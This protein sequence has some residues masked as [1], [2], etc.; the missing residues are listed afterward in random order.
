M[1][2]VVTFLLSLSLNGCSTNLTHTK[3]DLAE[4]RD[5][6]SS[7]TGFDLAAINEMRALS[8]DF[9]QSVKEELDY[10]RTH[11]LNAAE[12]QHVLINSIQSRK[13]TEERSQ[14]FRSMYYHE[15]G[16]YKQSQAGPFIEPLMETLAETRAL[17]EEKHQIIL[18]KG[19]A[20]L[21]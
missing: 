5:L 11:D 20:K 13:D 16:S 10:I 14:L 2:I 6:V 18:A 21:K 8:N 1:D 15:D 4:D 19:K 3:S 7:P 17:L 9:L 12:L